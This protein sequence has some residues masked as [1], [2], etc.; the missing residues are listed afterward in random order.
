MIDGCWL[1]R[2]AAPKMGE[3]R[4]SDEPQ[5]AENAAQTQV[6]AGGDANGPERESGTSDTAPGKFERLEAKIDAIIDRLPAP[7]PPKNGHRVADFLERG[8]GTRI[9]AAVGVWAIALTIFAFWGEMVVRREE[10]QARTEE[11]EFRRLAQI[12]TAWE[13]LLTRA[14]GDIGKGN[15][16]NTLIAGGHE[17]GETDLSCAAVGEVENGTC[18][19]P[20]IYSS[21][22]ALQG[23]FYAPELWR[24]SAPMTRHGGQPMG[25]WDISFEE[26]SLPYFQ[27]H[28]IT[29]GPEFRGAYGYE[30]R[31]RYAQYSPFTW[32][33]GET[34]IFTLPEAFEGFRCESCAFYDSRLPLDAVFGFSSGALLDSFVEIPIDYA[35]RRAEDI[36]LGP[37]GGFSGRVIGLTDRP[38][39]FMWTDRALPPELILEEAV[40]WQSMAYLSYCAAEADHQQII[41]FWR[42]KMTVLLAD[43]EV[44]PLANALSELDTTIRAPGDEIVSGDPFLAA[45]FYYCGLSW[46]TVEP[47]MRPRIMARMADVFGNNTDQRRLTLDDY[48]AQRVVAPEIVVENPEPSGD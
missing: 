34:H 28:G 7:P 35:S 20:P 43:N 47:V 4:L 9:V 26:A 46:S 11:A 22:K 21:V 13:V 14:G 39:I 33:R 32:R 25:F 2:D 30:W 17:F 31:V 38:T 37:G 15:A 48:I 5:D 45:Q 8:W 36:D 40:S 6:S 41:E 23:E 42:D 44:T 12:A 10:R 29:L 19:N 18:V 16:L 3:F 27:G 1:K 24:E